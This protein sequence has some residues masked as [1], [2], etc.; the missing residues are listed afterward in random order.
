MK[1]LSHKEVSELSQ[2]F[3]NIIN[4]LTPEVDTK[5]YQDTLNVG[6]SNFGHMLELSQKVLDAIK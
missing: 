2:N 6:C 3:I 5:D 1:I 4:I